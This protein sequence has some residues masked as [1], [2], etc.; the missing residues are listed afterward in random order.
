MAELLL[1]P[2][3]R[4]W[5]FLP[6]MAITFLVG[7]IKHYL[8][9][10]LSNDKTVEKQQIIDSQVLI[11]SRLLRENGRFLPKESFVM[12]KNYFVNEETG[13]FVKQRRQPAA[14]KMPMND[15]K[16]MTEMVKGNFLNMIPMVVIGGWINWA[17]AGFLCTKV[18]FPLTFRFKPML[19]KDVNLVVLDASWVSAASWYIINLFGLKSMYT[20]VLG[21][22]NTADQTKAMQDQ[23]SGAA[24]SMPDD[25]NKAFKAESDNLC[26]TDHN[27]V[28]KSIEQKLFVEDTE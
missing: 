7:V 26:V 28:L 18:P 11:R 10:F 14:P 25:L 15:P 16:M 2:K 13:Y 23:M 22:N 24:L 17:Y 27:W 6:I 8:F 1:D 19:Q 3:I 20:L 21:E 5:V 12:R 9:I 4:F